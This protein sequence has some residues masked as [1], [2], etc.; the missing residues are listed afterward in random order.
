MQGV[1]SGRSASRRAVG[2][3]E[4]AGSDLRPLRP[5]GGWMQGVISGPSP[6]I[7]GRWIPVQGL[8]QCPGGIEQDAC[9]P[10]G[11]PGVARGSMYGATYGLEARSGTP[12]P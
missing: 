9:S 5:R 7:R 2:R 12:A 1:I 3:V 11:T 10:P 4:R 8:K 6:R